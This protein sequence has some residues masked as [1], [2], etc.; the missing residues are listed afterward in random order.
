[1]RLPVIQTVLGV[2]DDEEQIAL[3][4]RFT[5]KNDPNHLI[6]YVRRRGLS[7]VR[8]FDAAFEAVC[9][10]FD[11][12]V[13]FILVRF[14]ANAAKIAERLRMIVTPTPADLRILRNDVPAAPLIFDRLLTEALSPAWIDGL[15]RDGFFAGP[16]AGTTTP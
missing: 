13:E 4:K 1:M 10:N 11:N 2:D 7:A 12:A 3:W 15:L 5:K 16:P 6:K 9:A 8:P 14:R